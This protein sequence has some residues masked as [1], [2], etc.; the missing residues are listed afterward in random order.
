MVLN[1]Q[2]CSILCVAPAE[3][4]GKSTSPI[5][6][7]YKKLQCREHPNTMVIVG[8]LRR[9]AREQDSSKRNFTT[10]TVTTV[11]FPLGYIDAGRLRVIEPR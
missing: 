10:I 2:I 4:F 11:V 7:G 6:L 3:D 1:L 9:A 5:D 8:N